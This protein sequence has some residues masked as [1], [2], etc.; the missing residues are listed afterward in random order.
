[1]SFYSPVLMIK[2]NRLTPVELR[3]FFR[4]VFNFF[5][6][7]FSSVTNQSRNSNDLINHINDEFQLVHPASFD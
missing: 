7:Q 5:L 6:P 4:I 2:V 3:L 1:V